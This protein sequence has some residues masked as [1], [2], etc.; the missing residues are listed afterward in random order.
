MKTLI[1]SKKT[2][3]NY[4]TLE[5]DDIKKITEVVKFNDTKKCKVCTIDYDYKFD[6]KIELKTTDIVTS[7]NGN[8]IGN[9]KII[10][11]FPKNLVKRIDNYRGPECSYHTV[12]KFK[13]IDDKS[14]KISHY[15]NSE[16]DKKQKYRYDDNGNLTF[17]KEQNDY[18]IGIYHYIYNSNNDIVESIHE[19]NDKRYNSHKVY[20]YLF[21]YKYYNNGD[22]NELHLKVLDGIRVDTHISIYFDEHGYITYHT[23]HILQSSNHFK[24]IDPVFSDS[25]W[26]TVDHAVKYNKFISMYIELKVLPKPLLSKIK[27]IIPSPDKTK[28]LSK[29]ILLTQG[30][31]IKNKDLVS[32]EYFKNKEGYNTIQCSQ[33]FVDDDRYIQTDYSEF[34]LDKNN[35]ILSK[36]RINMSFNDCY[37]ELRSSYDDLNRITCKS[38]FIKKE[39]N[40][41]LKRDYIVLYKYE[42]EY[43]DNATHILTIQYCHKIIELETLITYDE[44]GRVIKEIE[45]KYTLSNDEDVTEEIDKFIKD[46]DIVVK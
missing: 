16:Y 46:T 11:T 34:Y 40:S 9:K 8:V 14:Y 12:D 5:C 44:R 3:N 18:Y 45:N 41:S 20:K 15:S 24:Y 29:I 42:S 26:E 30:N 6:A 13:I 43:S 10:S 1:K 37:Y 35:V 27:N 28:Y 19:I 31:Y 7:E 17:M 21:N 32:F 22:I 33:Y 36:D 23:D 4:E 25:N 39:N 2:I 38:H